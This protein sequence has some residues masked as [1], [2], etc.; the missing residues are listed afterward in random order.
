MST[1]SSSSIV[2]EPFVSRTLYN[3]SSTLSATVWRATDG[4]PKENAIVDDEQASPSTMSITRL[5]NYFQSSSLL[6]DYV[7]ASIMPLVSSSTNEKQ[8]QQSTK[9]R[10]ST[11]K[12]KSTKK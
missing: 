3:P 10:Q 12:K 5:S 7:T 2:L 11:K 4:A 6:T 8:T 1:A 9:K